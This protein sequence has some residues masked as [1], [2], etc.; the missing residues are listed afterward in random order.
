MTSPAALP[1]GRRARAEVPATSANLGPGFD[2][3]GLA[4]TMSDQVEAE[5]LVEGLEVEVSGQGAGR[6]PLDA[7]HLVVRVLCRALDELGHEAPGLRLVATNVV[8]HSRGLGSSASAIVAGI[9]LAWGLARPGEELD[10]NWACRLSSELEG[11]PDNA[12]AAVLGGIVLGHMEPGDDGRPG[13]QVVRLEPAEGLRCIVWVPEVEVPTAGAR[14]VLPETVPWADAIAQASS[15]AL[16][17]HALTTDPEQLLRGTRDLLHQDRRAA[18]MPDSARL[19]G[20]LR[21]HGVPAVISGAG[22]T[23]LAVGRS[24]QLQAHEA[25]DQ[26]GFVRHHLELGPGVQLS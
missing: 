10:L 4:L 12:C 17:V 16:L 6:V 26:T 13:V 5:V 24:E 23:V 22:P 3:L 25:V 19:M 15:A 11:H 1:V 14:A 20:E 9:A 8:P 2:C 7:R 18:L 21:A